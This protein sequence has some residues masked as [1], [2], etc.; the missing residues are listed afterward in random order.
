MDNPQINNIMVALA[1]NG[2]EGIVNNVTYPV[3]LYQKQLNPIL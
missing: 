2:D 1:M 3:W